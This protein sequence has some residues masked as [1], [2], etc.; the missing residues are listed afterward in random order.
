MHGGQ[1]A[2]S[3]GITTVQLSN[4]SPT[5]TLHGINKWL[6]I[7]TSYAVVTVRSA[8]WT[9][10]VLVFVALEFITRIYFSLH[11]NDSFEIVIKFENTLFRRDQCTLDIR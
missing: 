5:P 9:L 10:F 8:S 6:T 7:S 2:L 4:N 3:D 11:E 1:R